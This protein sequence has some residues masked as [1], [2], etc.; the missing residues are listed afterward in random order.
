[1]SS[2]PF[3]LIIAIL[4][5]S[6]YL[7]GAFHAEEKTYLLSNEAVSAAFG[8]TSKDSDYPLAPRNKAEQQ[9]IDAYRKTN[10]A[11]V[12]V[13]A[14]QGGERT[15]NQGTGSG[16]V[17]D[18]E[19]GLI[20]T[21]QHVISGARQAAVS[22][23][24]GETL[25]VRLIGEDVSSDIA[26]LQIVDPPSTLVEA[27]LGQS[28]NLEVG[29]RVLAIGNPFGLTRTLTT[30]IVSSLGRTIRAQ[31]GG[32][33]EGVIQTDA[34]INPGNSGGPLIDTAGRVVGINT[35]I[36]SRLGQNSGVG[37][38]VPVDEVRRVVPQLIQYGKV[39]RPII[40]VILADTDFGAVVEVVEPGSPADKSGIS[41]AS[42]LIEYAG[43]RFLRTDL[44]EADFIVEVNG[45][46]VRNS[47]E[48]K[49]ALQKL[50][51]EE[52]VKLTLRRGV[53]RKKRIVEV[54]PVLR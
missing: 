4:S 5:L 30:G 10:Q 15:L 24:S 22:L 27:R 9:I 18:K 3:Y 39:L 29:Q 25:A 8:K 46:T 54:T 49:D 20:V 45:K 47:F 13:I 52:S 42:R 50:S 33:I 19:K 28:S 40:G 43:K 6:G 36:K 12:N 51:T 16:V 1:M 11:V 38:A 32:L 44:R 7:L 41:G 21:N 14:L 34:A 23:A 2:K 26:L 53:T 31:N 17:I 37:L 48:V 35:A